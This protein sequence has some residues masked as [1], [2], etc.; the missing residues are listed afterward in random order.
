L[1]DIFEKHDRISELAAIFKSAMPK[2][3][4]IVTD[5][6]FRTE[7]LIVVVRS[8]DVFDCPF[9]RPPFFD[10]LQE[11]KSTV[12]WRLVILYPGHRPRHNMD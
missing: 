10:D 2:P 12:H 7:F 6:I 8:S 5:A 9:F 4:K 11:I 1:I 3:Q